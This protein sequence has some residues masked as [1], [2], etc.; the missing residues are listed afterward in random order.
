MFATMSF[1]QVVVSVQFQVQKEVRAE[2]EHHCACV[3][4]VLHAVLYL[5]NSLCSLIDI[6]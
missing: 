5:A 4:V 2:A 3:F 6:R 1:I